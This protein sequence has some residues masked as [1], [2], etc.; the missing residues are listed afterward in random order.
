MRKNK[1][2]LFYVSAVLFYLAAILNFVGGDHNSIAVVWLCL[3]STFLCL[4]S[5]YSKKSKENNNKDEEQPIQICKELKISVFSGQFNMVKQG[6]LALRC[7]AAFFI[8]KYY[9]L[10]KI[11]I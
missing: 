7:M 10:L 3:G 11:T 5:V 2:T 4:G 8:C 6:S 1:S 9:I